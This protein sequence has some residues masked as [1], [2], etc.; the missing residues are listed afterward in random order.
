MDDL[1]QQD[2]QEDFLAVIVVGLVHPDIVEILSKGSKNVVFV[3]S[4]PM[5]MYMIPLQW[6]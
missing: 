3:A 1:F 6:I 5:I 4:A 2:F